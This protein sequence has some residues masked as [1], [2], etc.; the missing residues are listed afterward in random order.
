MCKRSFAGWSRNNV[1]LTFIGI[2]QPNI[3]YV[4]NW[5]ET[6]HVNKK[7]SAVWP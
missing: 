6:T 3:V 7:K 2:I 1:L 4:V 5:F